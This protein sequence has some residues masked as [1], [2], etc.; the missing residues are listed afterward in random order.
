MTDKNIALLLGSFNPPH[1]GHT[2]IARWALTCAAV[3]EVW[4]VPT[5]QNPFKTALELAPWADRLAMIH[6]AFDGIE[7]VEIC[8]IENE[9]P[10]P[11]YT[12]NTIE[13]LKKEYPEFHFS[14]LCGGDIE[15]ELPRWHRARE[16]KELVDFIIYPRAVGDVGDV[17]NSVTDLRPL[18]AE[19]STAI[20]S[21]CLMEGVTPGVL[22]YI[23]EHALYFAGSLAAAQAAFM[24]G[25]FAKVLNLASADPGSAQIQKMAE[26]AR[27]IL[28]FRYTDIYNP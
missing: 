28:D 22:A 5:P 16:L 12:I 4:V 13:H 15:R 9:L 21:G 3:S 26:M 6:L 18:Y 20:R 1:K 7:G 8:T 27:E 2:A 10:A 11:H 14:I 24:A 23:E 19:N 17:G 25:D